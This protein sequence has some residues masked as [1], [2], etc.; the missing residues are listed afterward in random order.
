MVFN[1]KI[2]MINMER[3]PKELDILTC[4]CLEQNFKLLS[5]TDKKNKRLFLQCQNKKCAQLWEI[6]EKMKR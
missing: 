5:N 6:K 4:L 2:K 3:L 1:G